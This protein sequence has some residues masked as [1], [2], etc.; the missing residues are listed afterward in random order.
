MQDDGYGEN[1][2][3]L[4][5]CD[6]GSKTARWWHVYIYACTEASLASMKEMT[7]IIIACGNEEIHGLWELLHVGPPGG[8]CRGFN[9]SREGG[10]RRFA[11]T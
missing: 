6:V 4:S 2:R 7:A 10:C 9:L 1:H 8:P 5:T 11:L 3:R